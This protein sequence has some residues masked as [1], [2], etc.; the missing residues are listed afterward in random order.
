MIKEDAGEGFL[1]EHI[2]GTLSPW[3]Q[4]GDPPCELTKDST[5]MLAA[6]PSESLSVYMT[7]YPKDEVSATITSFPG[8]FFFFVC[9]CSFVCV[10]CLLVSLFL[11]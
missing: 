5:G 1:F 6:S 9:V 11:F 8:C 2:A 3:L 4:Y 10:F 7:W